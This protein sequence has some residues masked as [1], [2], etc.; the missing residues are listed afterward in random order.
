MI[1]DR[2]RLRL[3]ID[4]ATSALS[5]AG[6][7][8]ARTDAEL[9][10]AHLT[11]IDRGLLPFS[12]DVGPDFYGRYDEAVAERARRT[13]LQH[14]TGIA[15]FGPLLL[16]VG[17]GVFIPRPETEALLEW[18]VGQQLPAAPTIV[19][20]CTGSGAL[21][22]ALARNWPHANVLGVDSDATALRYA[23]SN[24]AAG[25]VHWVQADVTEPGVLPHLAGKVDLLV[26]N[27]PYIPDSAELQ[28]EVANHDPAHALFGGADG[29]AIIEPIVG[30]AIGWLKPGGLFVVEHDDTTSAETVEMVEETGQFGN[31][32]A[33]RDLAGCP[34]FVTA[35]RM[36]SRRLDDA[37]V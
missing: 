26:A 31:V 29:M 13:P 6:I 36:A 30:L 9:L 7:E 2:Q 35:A 25:A 5:E 17:P 12:D 32:I 14:I 23:R 10:A 15:A 27:P 21:A 16:R 1:A 24:D 3:A 11:G 20:L 19:D 18:A 33:H 34:R 22:I 8:S 37:G 28:P 4:A